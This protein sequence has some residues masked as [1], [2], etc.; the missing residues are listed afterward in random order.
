M[1]VKTAAQAAQNWQQGFGAAGQKWA[2]GIQNTTVNPMALAAAQLP[3]AIANYTAA[4]QPGGAMATGLAAAQ[5]SYWKSQCAAASG[6]LAQGA[7]KGAAK[8]AKAAGALQ[9][10]LAAGERRRCS[11]ARLRSGQPLGFRGIHG[12]HEDRQGRGQVSQGDV[13]VEDWRNHG[14]GPPNGSGNDPWLV[15]LVVFLVITTMTVLW[16][17]YA[18]WIR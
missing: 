15:W 5:P 16:V 7:T 17:L 1:A 14:F 12:G 13:M 9:P 6:K 18:A 10:I 4:A 11:S 2:Q 3:K 8:Y